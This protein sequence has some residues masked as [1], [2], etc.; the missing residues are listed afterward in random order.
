MLSVKLQRAPKDGPA[1][2]QNDILIADPRV[3]AAERQP[4]RVV[5]IAFEDGPRQ[6]RVKLYPFALSVAG[7]VDDLARPSRSMISADGLGRDAA[8]LRQRAT[9]VRTVA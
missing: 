3:P 2:Q 5:G 4:H 9:Q 7:L 8:L 1:P 6:P